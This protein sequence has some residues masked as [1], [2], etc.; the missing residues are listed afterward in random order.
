LTASGFGGGGIRNQIGTVRLIRSSVTRN[1]ANAGGGG[2]YVVGGTVLELTDSS[3]AENVAGTRGGGIDGATGTVS[4][5]HSSVTGNVAANGGGI[6][7]GGLTFFPASVTLV[8]STVD[9]NS[10]VGV[11]GAG[12]GLLNELN[13]TVAIDGSTIADNSA[14][15]SGGGIRNVGRTLSVSRSVVTGNSALRGAGLDNADFFFGALFV[16]HA[17]LVDTAIRDNVATT[18]GGG[19]FNAGTLLGTNV[20]FAGNQPDDC[21]GACA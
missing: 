11:P 3:V 10:A 1:T 5:A 14:V 21:F 16:G 6:A 17:T 12:G 20:V 2:I 9:G 7:S 18:V 13:G 19:I 8:D 4:L 15:G